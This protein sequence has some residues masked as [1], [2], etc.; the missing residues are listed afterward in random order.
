[1]TLVTSDT[2]N[3]SYTKGKG[4]NSYT[5]CKGRPESLGSAMSHVSK[6]RWTSLHN[7]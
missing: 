5:K 2:G 1:M 4:Q 7:R 3:D 6:M